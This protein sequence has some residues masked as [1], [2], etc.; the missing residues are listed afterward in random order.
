MEKQ[1]DNDG[2]TKEELI[3][4]AIGI[5]TTQLIRKGLPVTTRGL[6]QILMQEEENTE[7]AE[8]KAIYQDARKRV[9]QKMQ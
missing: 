6:I 2:L 7:M 8:R 4:E 9:Q 3:R 5:A 1:T